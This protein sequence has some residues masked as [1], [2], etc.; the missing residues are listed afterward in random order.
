MVR[1]KINGFYYMQVPHSNLMVKNK[2]NEI[3]QVQFK[4]K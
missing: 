3:M 2:N 1:T 4:N